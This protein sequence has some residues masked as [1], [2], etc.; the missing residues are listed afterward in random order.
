MSHNALQKRVA[1]LVTLLEEI[2]R[3]YEELGGV[4]QRKLEGMRRADTEA[5]A[6]ASN[7]ERFLTGRLRERDGLRRQLMEL[8]GDQLGLPAADARSMTVSDVASRVGEPLA[9]RL[10]ALADSTRTLMQ[11]T[12]EGNRLAGL[13]GKEMLGHFRQVYASLTSGA[14]RNGV[15]SRS[16]R[17][18]TTGLTQMFE[19]TG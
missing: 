17:P 16:G 11:Q 3:L 10:T 15:Y 19:A 13:V 7:R 18:E 8:I 5:M 2:R 9:G 12:A 6:S 1:Q 4:I 14:S